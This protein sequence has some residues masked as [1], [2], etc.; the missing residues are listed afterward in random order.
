MHSLIIAE[1]PTS[2]RKI[3]EALAE[4]KVE[5]VKKNTVSYYRIHRD[6]KDIVVVPAVG[7]LFVLQ[8]KNPSVKWSYPIFETRWVPSHT[9]K[10]NA[11]SR[12][13]FQNI[14]SLVKGADS[15]ISAT[16]FDIEGSTIAFNI[17][18][19]ICNTKEGRRMRFSTLTK[20]DIIDA[21]EN[22]S[23]K[24]DFPQ[25][26]A[27]LTRAQ[28]DWYFGINLSRALTLALEHV[29]GYWVLS[30]GRVQGPTLELL[31]K[32]EREIEAFRPKPYWEIELRGRIEDRA[33]TASHEKDKF[34]KK[35]EAD[36]VMAGCRGRDGVV[37][38]IEKR[39]QKQYPPFPFDLTTLQRESY[40]LFGYSPRQTL[41]IA[42]SLYEHAVI[43][44]P[45]TSSQKLPAKI[46]Y[47]TILNKLWKQR[48]Y[49]KFCE[50]L[51]ARKTLKPNEGKKTDSAH[52]AIYPTGH[53][54][55]MNSY[56]R[57]LY[58]LIVRR[59]LAVFAEPALREHMRV[60]INVNG[61]RF[62]V[63]GVKTLKANWMEYYGPHAKFKEQVLPEIQKGET[64]NVKKLTM[65]DKETEPPNRFSQASV[66]KE[67]EELGLGTKAT[68]AGILQTL[69]DRSYIKERSIEVTDIGRA[70]AKTLEQHS[71][72]IMSPKLTSQ[73]DRDMEMIE[74]GKEKRKKVVENTEKE[75]RRIL[76]DFR[77][78]EKHIG[79]GIYEAVREYEKEIHTVGTCP[80]CGKKLMIMHSHK[81]GKRFVG[82]TG[83]PKCTNSFPL[84]Q[85]GYVEVISKKC[86]DPKCKLHLLQ[87]KSKGRRPWRF[88]LVHGYEN[89]IVAK[90]KGKTASKANAK[91]KNTENK[92]KKK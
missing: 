44:Y 5:T 30:I 68:R 38:S 8:E 24:L 18:R 23:K 90:I 14:K 27:G 45:R 22:A 92:R 69:Y 50:E 12:K 57:K 66:L 47:K 17:L 32:R 26:E 48:P 89:K 86:P 63:H 64:V 41:S 11:W 70:V 3:A 15:F 39:E 20:N 81:T 76:E 88:C 75:L 21:Y 33:V 85:H 42:Q 53:V 36:A 49:S 72:E 35:P 82:C 6:G 61:E 25:I 16:D 73:L 29:G 34:W 7:H 10:G 71:P 51:L 4:G 74:T 67:M 87:V 37:D 40:K 9:I 56:Q 31:E 13:Y 59:F 80:K 65:F 83:Y 2:A 52:P 78:H 28:V 43:S 62:I 60:V 84:P 58:D 91:S 46:G 55:K 19:F 79:K 1:K 54:I 77:Q